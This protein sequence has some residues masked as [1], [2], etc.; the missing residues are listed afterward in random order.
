MF[1]LTSNIGRN[2]VTDFVFVEKKNKW[3]WPDVASI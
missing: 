1:H 3:A 2:A